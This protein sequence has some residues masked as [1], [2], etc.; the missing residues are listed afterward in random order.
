MYDIF[1]RLLS[2]VTKE[3]ITLVTAVIGAIGAV[4]TY[5]HQ[6]KKL[7][8][9]LLEVRNFD[10]GYFINYL[11]TNKSNL[12]ISITELYLIERSHK[13]KSFITPET[14]STECVTYNFNTFEK[15]LRTDKFPISLSPLQARSCWVGF[16]I[17]EKNA[18]ISPTHLTFQFETTRGKIKIKSLPLSRVN[19]LRNRT[20]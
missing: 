4:H 12:P 17:P 10:N 15:H 9:Q 2:I 14:I 16:A 6:R 3:N 20:L 19:C 13:I 1:S 5:F 11:V 18:L 8:I 7:V